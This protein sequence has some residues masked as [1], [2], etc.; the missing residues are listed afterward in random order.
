MVPFNHTAHYGENKMYFSTDIGCW[1]HDI[2]FHRNA[3]FTLMFTKKLQLLWSPYQGL[4][5][6]MNPAGGLASPPDHML[7]GAAQPWRQID[8]LWWQQVPAC[9]SVK[10]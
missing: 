2:L 1:F 9:R 3:Y 7:C 4:C 5:P 10:I 6:W 8:T